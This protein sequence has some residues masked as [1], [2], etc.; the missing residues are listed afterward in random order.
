MKKSVLFLVLIAVIALFIAFAGCKKQNSSPAAPASINTPN[1]TE[2][3]IALF[4]STNSPTITTTATITKTIFVTSTPTSTVTPTFTPTSTATNSPVPVAYTGLAPVPG[5]T[6]TQTDGIN[7]FSHSISAFQIGE[8][9]VTYDLWYTVRIWAIGNGY[10]FQNSGTEGYNG[11]IGAAPTT[12]KY[13]PVTAI[14]WR[15]IIVWCNA[16]SQKTGLASVYYSDSGFTTPIKSSISGS[17]GSVINTTAG[18][19]DNPY[20]NWSANGYRLPTEGEYQCAASYKDGSNWTPNN[21]ASGATDTVSDIPATEVVAW[22]HSNC[23]NTQAV[24]GKT[25]NTLGIYDMSGNVWEWCWDWYGTY[26]ATGSANYTGPASGS[27]RVIRGGSYSDAANYMQVG[28]RYYD[29][30]YDTGSNSGFR[31]ARTN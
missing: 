29:S 2:T 11:T 9:Q 24:G 22:C 19:F 5:G 4:T 26:P 13:Q 25:P 3:Y 7:S 10:T 30:P 28:Y 14:N 23:D 8:Y 16:Y 15:D 27:S 31:I 21:Y 20:V 17:Y 6:F 1:Y 12:A 18:S